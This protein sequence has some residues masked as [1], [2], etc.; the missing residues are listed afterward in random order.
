MSET[1]RRVLEMLAAGKVSVAEAERLLDAL[2][3]PAAVPRTGRL[4][5]VWVRGKDGEG[6]KLHLPLTL[7]RVALEFLP[8]EHR[9]LLEKEGIDLDALLAGLKDELPEGRLVEVR[10]S[11]GEV[12]IEVV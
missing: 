4:L 8:A 9:A 1:R 6:V 5:R 12:V 11:E 3:A 10:G 2:E 7:A